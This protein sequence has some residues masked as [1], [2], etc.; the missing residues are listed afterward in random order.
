[1]CRLPGQPGDVGYL[2]RRKKEPQ[3][4]PSR[5]LQPIRDQAMAMP[6]EKPRD[7]TQQSIFKS[8]DWAHLQPGGKWIFRRGEMELSRTKRGNAQKREHI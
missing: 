2:D 5:S 1:M 8:T 7:P 6:N 4:L 3:L